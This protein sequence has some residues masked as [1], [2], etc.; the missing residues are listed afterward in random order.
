MKIFYF[1]LDSRVFLLRNLP[2]GWTQL[3]QWMFNALSK[4][5][6]CLSFFHLTTKNPHIT[7]IIH[8]IYSIFLGKTIFKFESYYSISKI[9][10]TLESIRITNISYI[11]IKFIVISIVQNSKN[12]TVLQFNYFYFVWSNIAI[13]L[14]KSNF[15]SIIL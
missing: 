3:W 11:S 10:L 1:P 5:T 15:N 8:F 13:E 14:L 4:W 6:S 12:T 2:T 7:N 9:F